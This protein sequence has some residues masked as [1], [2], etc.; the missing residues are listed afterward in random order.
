MRALQSVLESSD[1]CKQAVKDLPVTAF[2]RPNLKDYLVRARLKPENSEARV[3][4]TVKCRNKRL[5]ICKNH[6]KIGHSFISKK[7]N[8]FYSINY[9]L[10]CNSD[11]VVFLISCKVCRHQYVGST[12]T[13]FHFLFNN[14]KSRINTHAKSSRNDKEM[15]DLI[16]KHFCSYG[17]HGAESV[18]FRL[19]L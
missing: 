19:C 9:Q 2:R 12:V 7:T 1:R 3:K 15:D 6:L 17:H 10:D 14:H 5:M 16:Y 4:G 8:K 18:M 13:P 11:N